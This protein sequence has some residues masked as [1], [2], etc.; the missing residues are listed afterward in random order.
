MPKRDLERLRAILFKAESI[1]I[2]EDDYVSGYIDMM[3]DLSA[4]DAYQLLLMRDAGLI[5]GKDAGL[6]LF[7]I[8]NAGHDFLDAVRD[9]GI[10]EKT[11]SRIVKAGGSATLDVVKEIA[12]SLIS[13]AVLG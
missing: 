13:R 12:V 9:E 3:S 1:D 11:K 2:N 10:W 6:G 4:E 7:R 5:E 8:T